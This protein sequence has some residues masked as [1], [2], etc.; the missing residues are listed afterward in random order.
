MAKR[1]GLILGAV[2]SLLRKKQGADAEPVL[3]VQVTPFELLNNRER[4]ARLCAL[5]VPKDERTDRY[6][7]ALDEYD[8]FIRIPDVSE[9][10]ITETELH[11]GT[12]I[13]EQPDKKGV[14]HEIGEFMLSVTSKTVRWENLTRRLRVG[15]VDGDLWHAPCVSYNNTLCGQSNLLKQISMALADGDLCEVIR[16]MIAGTRADDYV[17]ETSIRHWPLATSQKKVRT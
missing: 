14:Y 7:Q 16:L 6:A 1:D 8:E 12:V 17:D 15:G 3:E 2:R 11:V 4:F 9:F 10:T 13:I 5:Y